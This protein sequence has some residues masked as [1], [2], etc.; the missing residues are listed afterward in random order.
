MWWGQGEDENVLYGQLEIITSPAYM[1]E[2]VVSMV[3]DKI[4]EYLKRGIKL[5]ISSRGVGSL[6]EVNGENVVQDDFELICFDLVASP[7]TPG[8][9]LFPQ[10]NEMQVGEDVKVTGENLSE[11]TDKINDALTKFLL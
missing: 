11:G 10:K 2:G 5:G 6:K 4:V 1:K 7:S 3:G 9:Y 8:A